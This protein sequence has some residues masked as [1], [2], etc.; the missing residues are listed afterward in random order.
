MKRAL[1][2]MQGCVLEPVGDSVSEA[3][4]GCRG[5]TS[6]EGRRRSPQGISTKAQ[7]HFSERLKGPQLMLSPCCPM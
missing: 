7:V 1:E 6:G 2:R 4:R 3:P 5:P